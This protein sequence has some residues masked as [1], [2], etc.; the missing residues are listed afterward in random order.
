[1]VS[2]VNNIT[3]AGNSNIQRVPKK[4]LDI[5]DFIQLFI[6]QLQYQDP[7]NPIEN[8]EMAIQLALF[9]QVDQ[10]FKINETL[11]TLVNI[12]KSLD[13]AYIS[14][15]VGKKVKVETNVGRVENGEFIGGEFNLD[16]PVNCLEIVI[17]DDKG[18]LV[19][20][21]KLNGL[22]A[23]NYKIEWD[24]TDLE[25]NKVPDGNYIFSIIIPENTNQII[26]PTMIAKVTGAKLGDNTQIVINENYTLD[27]KDIKELIGE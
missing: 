10:L 16:E 22:R 2:Q 23:G 20:K 27:L 18:N 25:G 8:N 6:T 26:T 15:L 4:S 14:N 5:Q 19:D 1:M 21:I 12:A 17:K 24:A 11:G 9:N 7:M 3:T 13:L